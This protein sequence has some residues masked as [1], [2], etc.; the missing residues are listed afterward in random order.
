MFINAHRWDKSWVSH[1]NV[2]SQKIQRS[3]DGSTWVD[4]NEIQDYTQQDIDAAPDNK[5]VMEFNGQIARYWRWYVADQNCATIS[6]W[7]FKGVKKSGRF[8]L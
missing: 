2:W 3:E 1:E 7:E 4:V 6:S 5:V 8:I